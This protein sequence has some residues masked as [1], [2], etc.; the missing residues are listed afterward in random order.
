MIWNLPA[1]IVEPYRDRRL[2]FLLLGVSGECSGRGRGF[3]T[4][5]FSEA[6]HVTQTSQSKEEGT[7]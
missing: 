7:I 6:H 3:K 1:G 2:T 5:T 4:Q